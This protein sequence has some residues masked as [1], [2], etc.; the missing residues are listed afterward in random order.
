M[1]REHLEAKF[2]DIAPGLQHH[3]GSVNSTP[4]YPLLKRNWGALL[5]LLFPSGSAIS[6]MCL[7]STSKGPHCTQEVSTQGVTDPLR[8]GLHPAYEAATPPVTC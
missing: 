6:H 8:V 1:G 3:V 2:P 5:P 7:P 4:I